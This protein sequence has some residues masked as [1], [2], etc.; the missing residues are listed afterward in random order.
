MMWPL[1]LAAW[2]LAGIALPT[3]DRSNM[4]GRLWRPGERRP[5]DD[6]A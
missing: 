2:R 6:E 1:A 3:Y 5:E 4:P